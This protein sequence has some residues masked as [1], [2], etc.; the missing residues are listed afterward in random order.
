MADDAQKLALGVVELLEVRVRLARGLQGLR[1]LIGGLA[2]DGHVFDHHQHV[3]R[4]APRVGDGRRRELQPKPVPGSCCRPDLDHAAIA[5]PGQ[6]RRFVQARRGLVVGAQELRPRGVAHGLGVVLEH[7][8]Q[9]RVGFEHLA[10]VA[11]AGD[12]NR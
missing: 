12:A 8:E 4:R 7:V 2:D 5:D 1:Q 9:R 10:A 6:E 3:L 11:D